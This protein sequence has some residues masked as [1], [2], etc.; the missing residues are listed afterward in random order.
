MIANKFVARPPLSAFV[1]CFW[2]SAGA[3]ETHAKER[4]MPNGEPNIVFTL[5]DDP[6]RVYDAEDLTRYRSYCPA[7]LS[8]PRTGCFVIETR[9]E[10]RVFGIQFQPG[11]AFPFF[12]AP[13]S[14]LADS[15]FELEAFW[16][17]SAGELRE[18]SQRKGL[19]EAGTVRTSGFSI[20]YPKSIGV[21]KSS[22][23]PQKQTPWVNERLAITTTVAMPV[24]TAMLWIAS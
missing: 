6:I 14:E 7:V 22:I 21:V 23:K 16:K 20:L 8:G 4:L 11:G 17:K 9:Q 13:T 19:A 24:Q 3:P 15:D 2:Y 1:K 18:Q 12:R 10:D 5:R